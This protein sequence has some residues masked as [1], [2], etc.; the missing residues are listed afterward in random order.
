MHLAGGASSVRSISLVVVLPT[1]LSRPRSWHRC[2]CVPPQPDGPVPPA[3]HPPRHGRGD[4]PH[5]RKLAFGNDKQAA[6]FAMAVVAKSCPST[7]S[8]LD[9]E[10]HFTGVIVRLSIEIP[11][12]RRATRRHGT[13]AHGG[14]H[15]C[16]RPQPAHCF[17]SSQSLP[18]F[19]VIGKRQHSC[20]NRLPSSWPLPATI[21]VRSPA[22]ISCTA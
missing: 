2:G 5:G 3:H 14:N 4:A 7:L 12:T 16:C 10:E 9:G 15:V 21:S 18:H 22:S 11:V 1:E 17:N 6:P 20:A 8:P 19:D 13:P